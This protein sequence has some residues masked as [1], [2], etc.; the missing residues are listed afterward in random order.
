MVKD[1]HRAII[2]TVKPNIRGD[3]IMIRDVDSDSIVMGIKMYIIK[4]REFH[5]L[6]VSEL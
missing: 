1:R 3:E 5:C 2:I 4:D 6:G